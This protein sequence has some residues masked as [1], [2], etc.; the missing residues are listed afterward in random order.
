LKMLHQLGLELCDLVVAGADHPDERCHSSTHRL[1]DE[2][3]RLGLGGPQSGLDLRGALVDAAL[4][5]ST[6]ERRGDLGSRELATAGRC[7]CDRKDPESGRRGELREGR[8]R[9]WVELPQSGAE[10]IGLPLA[11]PDKA[12]MSSCQHLHR[13]G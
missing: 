5:S 12:L 9:S 7:R 11:G 3:W 4:T 2:K 13:L 10:L 8:E 1:G 6:A